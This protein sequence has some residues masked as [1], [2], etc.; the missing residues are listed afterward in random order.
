MALTHNRVLEMADAVAA[1]AERHQEIL[2]DTQKLLDQNSDLAI[3]WGAVATPSYITEDGAGNI[4]GRN[5]TRQAVS[6]AIYSL[7]QT[8]NALTNQAVAQGDHLGN[9]NQLASA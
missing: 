3:D 7:L 5:Y 9:L 1:L 4:D 8:V 2:S 6:N